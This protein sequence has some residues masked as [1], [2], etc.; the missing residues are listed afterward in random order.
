MAQ[1]EWVLKA[2][3]APSPSETEDPVA[4]V[5]LSESERR[6]I[7]FDVALAMFAGGLLLLAVVWRYLVPGSARLSELVAGMA[8]LLVVPPVAVGAWHS[9]RSP[10]LH[11]VTDRL[12]ALAMLAAWATGDM[13]TAALLPIVM[14]ISHALEERSVLGSREAIR[15]LGQLTQGR[16][17]RFRSDGSIEEIDARTLAL[18]DEIE[19][20]PGARIPADGIVKA[21]GSNVDNAPI[22]GESLPV[23]AA[24]GSGVFAGAL[25]LDGL[26]RIE[27]TRTGDQSTLGQIVELMRNA[28]HSKPPV[29]QLLERYMGGYLGLVLLIAAIVWFS[30]S[31]TSAVLAVIVAA[32]PCAL[33]L[34]APATAVAGITVGARHGVLFKNAAFLEKMADLDSLIIDKT[35]T[36][37]YGELSVTRVLAE[38][39][40][41]VDDAVMLAA[42]LGAGSAHPLSRG[43]VA[44]AR[45]LSPHSV[46][47]PIH[48]QEE[49][50]YGIVAKTMI[51]VAVLG[52][53]ELLHKHV[54]D[55]PPAPAGLDGPS[56]GIAL[57]GRLLARFEF[58]DSCRTEAA[59]ALSDLKALGLSRQA[60]LTGD[61]EAVARRIAAQV[62]IDTVRADA[63]PQDKLRFVIDELAAGWR[64]LVVGDGVNDA[65]AL[66][67]GATGIAM[68]GR[69]IDIA[70]AAA[71]IVLIH[72]DLRCIGAAVRLGRLCRK[73]SATNAAIGLGWTV[74]TISLAAGGV[75]GAIGAA[76]LHNV[77]TLFVILN[78]GRVLRFEAPCKS[79]WRTP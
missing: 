57:N 48:M 14:I 38:P 13:F 67:A 28:E 56:C 7:S 63:L 73:T 72:D 66:K 54:S 22:T 10:D 5:I 36:L 16:V 9:L 11:G 31:N 37:T 18:C 19:V 46:R 77:G 59:D 62:G 53:E 32:C 52:R 78:A 15:A 17:R 60:M 20:L 44:Y 39:G 1:V 43:L 29:T 61:K 58:A 50:G 42:R 76:V 47:P 74:A 24:G 79:A 55:L 41:N 40:V 12:I 35:G 49:H 33:V 23:F 51:G 26:L 64:P 6:K 3:I 27:I 30:S 71:D 69:G 45:A 68:G 8:S 25:N 4:G 34:A 75:I 65:L 21:G 70:A 2:D